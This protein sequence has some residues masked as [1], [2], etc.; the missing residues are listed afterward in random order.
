MMPCPTCGAPERVSSFF[1]DNDY[2][3]IEACQAALKPV[4]ASRGEQA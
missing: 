4:P 1:E 2:G 3:A